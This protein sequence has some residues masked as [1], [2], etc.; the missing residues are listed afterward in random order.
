MT[1]S[2]PHGETEALESHVSSLSEPLPAVEPAVQDA[3]VGLRQGEV[4]PRAL[5][6]PFLAV[7]GAD[8]VTAADGVVV[9]SQTCDITQSNRLTLQV[10]PLVRLETK[11]AAEARDGKRP[12]YVHVPELGNDA[13]A[14][15]EVIATASK[16]AIVGLPHS[17]GVA[18][19]AARRRFARDVARRFA[20]FAFPDEVTPWLRPLETV[21]AAKARRPTSPEGKLLQQVLELRIEAG[22]GW[23]DP[24]YDLTLVIVVQPG[25]LPTFPADELPPLSGA[26]ASKFAGKSATEL[27]LLLVDEQ[28]PADRYWLWLA[29]GDAWARRCKPPSGAERE[30]VEAVSGGAVDFDVVPDDEYTLDRWR[31]SET[32][33]L[34]HLSGPLL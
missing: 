15:L 7:E 17:P 4:L 32:L 29:L 11:T 6:L 9:L 3:L 5:E 34:D 13:F 22:R 14:D 26:Y 1:D 18:S 16:A 12:R 8:V 21:M 10:A 2:P 27:A 23:A 19:D 33:D 28:V 25:T 24:P 31:R 20:R 30:V